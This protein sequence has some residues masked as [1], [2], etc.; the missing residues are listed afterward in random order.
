[1]YG[2]GDSD[3]A[4][5]REE[6]QFFWERGGAVARDLDTCTRRKEVVRKALGI[7]IDIQSNSKTPGRECREC[8]LGNYW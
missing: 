2:K 8:G 7:M 5:I 3:T 4:A 6:S 1:M